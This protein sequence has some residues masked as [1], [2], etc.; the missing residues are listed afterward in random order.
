MAKNQPNT[1]PNPAKETIEMLVLRP[2]RIQTEDVSTWTDAVNQF[3]R[4]YR[5]KLYNLLDNVLADPVL[6]DALDKR[7]NAITNAEI[8]FMKDG[9]TVEE[10]DDLI[11][12]PEFEELIREILLSRAWGKSVIDVSFNPEFDIF[13]I[14]R[15]H[16]RIDKMERPLKERRRYI[17]DQEQKQTGYEYSED[18]YIIECGKDDDM[19]FLFRAAIYV[20][21]KRGGFGDWAQFAEIF[22]MP[23]LVGKYSGA[24]PATKAKLFQALSEIGGQP[25]AAIPKEADLEVIP[26]N[27]QG[28]NTLYK[29][30][31]DACN[32]EILIAVL[33]NLMTTL[34]GSSRSQSEVHQET[35]EEI[36]KS[37]R[38]FVQRIL[39]RKLLPLLL[40]RG[41]PVAGGYFSF[42]DQ[43]ESI[44][45]KERLDMAIRLK[46][47]ANVPVDD[48]T[49]YEISG[50][51]KAQNKPDKKEPEPTDPNSPPSKGGVPD[52]GGGGGKK[53]KGLRNFFAEAPAQTGAAKA[54][55]TTRLRR[56]ITGIIN[57]SDDY[58]INFD[59]LFNEALKEVY[60]GDDSPVNARLFDITNNAVQHAFSLEFGQES[61]DWGKGNAD[62][63]RE[64][65]LNGALFSAFKAHALT[66]EF[67][68]L[69]FDENGNQK[70][71]KQFK[72][73]S[74]ALKDQ[75]ER[76]LQTQYN[77]ALKSTR[78]AINFRRYLETEKTYPNLEYMESRAKHKRADHLEYVGTILP[79]RHAWWLKHLPPGDWNCQC[80][81]K[82]TKKKPTAVPGE[83]TTDPVFSNNPGVSAKF[84][85]YEQT[86]Y[87]QNTTDELRQVVEEFAKRAEAIRQKLAQFEFTRKTFKSGGY[88]DKPSG[89][90][91]KNEEAKNMKTYSLLA[92]EYGEK[93]AL[94][95]VDDTPGKRN[96]DAINLKQYRYSDAKTQEGGS[97]KNAIQ[98]G[99]KTASKQKAGEVVIFLNRPVS[100]RE[101]KSGLKAA[102]QKGRAKVVKQVIIIESDG[103][104]RRYDADQ[105]RELFK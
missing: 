31:K 88:V 64:Y 57:L 49:F 63:I 39:N 26:N 66:K 35:Q 40:K 18:P 103:S 51:P 80:W 56:S 72:N 75:D 101:I 90:Q 29:D 50:I 86:P 61:I 59:K 93:Y 2:A 41:Y 30:F 87:Y 83:D 96:P 36:A 62:F 42:P 58:A 45:T 95:P 70:T 71:F 55:F 24:D 102:F 79:I 52:E 94:L 92:K 46:T 37:D 21:Y 15:K 23:F 17:L 25:R 1:S 54:S 65:R 20:I 22:G 100:F 7:V 69:V 67:N 73:D 43:G 104:L 53:K 13:S 99:I 32:E 16:I 33:G 12:T 44:T 98:G 28:S 76:Y 48:D 74:L 5:V 91:N 47:E 78:A 68:S 60:S 81:V 97:V 89:G 85:N 3:K 105:L 9:N 34:D 19:G 27:S 4:G 11:D 14:P 8:A 77:T 38:R 82:P 84:I 10:M 6:A